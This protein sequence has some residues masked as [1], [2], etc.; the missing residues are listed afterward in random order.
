V[1]QQRSGMFG[2]RSLFLVVVTAAT[3][4]V[5]SG[6]AFAQGGG[7]GGRGMFGGGGDGMLPPISSRQVDQYGKLL[8]F[9]PDQAEAASAL[10]EG[11]SQQA[12]MAGKAMREAGEKMRESF[13]NGGGPDPEVFEKM[14]EATTKFR[15]DRKKLDDA[16]FADLKSLITPEQEAKWPSVERAHRRNSTMRWGRMSGERVDLVSLVEQ[17]KFAAESNAA[18]MPLL[19]SYEEEL[20]RELARRNELYEDAMEKMMEM[21]REGNMEGLQDMIEK[22]REAGKRVRELNRKYYRQINDVISEDAKPAFE[23]AFKQESYPDIYRRG[24]SGR[25]ADAAIGMADLSTEQKETISQ[26]NA[27]YQASLETVNEKLAKAQE[28]SEENFNL[29]NMAGRNWREEG[30]LAD[31]RRERREM[32][33][34]F[35]DDVKG[36]LTEEQAKRLPERNEEEVE[37]GQRGQRGQRRNET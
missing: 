36:A 35:I 12:A 22:G 24:Y 11:Y 33:R 3:L 15:A 19:A 32:D 8:S 2:I 18:V 37:G 20:D 25:V 17:Q 7:R 5:S 28:E 9:T 23:K 6:T 1:I 4:L 34:K 10:I 13:R 29:A 21:R 26:L 27:R 31:L 14:Q 16:L 30:P